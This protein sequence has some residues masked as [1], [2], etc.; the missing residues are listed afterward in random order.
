MK[1]IIT[2]F[3]TVLYF[4]VN[5]QTIFTQPITAT[6]A[7]LGVFGTANLQIDDAG[8][9]GKIT[10]PLIVVE[11]FDSGLLGIENVFGENHIGTFIRKSEESESTSL[12]EFLTG[13]T[14]F[15]FGDQDFDIIY[16]NWDNGND[17]LQRNAF[18]LEE[19]IIWVN[20][21]K[22]N[23]G[24]TTPNVVLGQ[25]MGGIIARYALADM[26][27][28]NKN[29]DTSLYISHDA[30]HQGANIPLGIQY[31]ARHMIDQ[32]VSTPLGDFNIN[33]S[34]VGGPVTIE[35]I[36]TLLNAPGTK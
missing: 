2:L 15:L 21:Q 36:K 10:K 25:S 23:A 32:F 31:F 20:A 8:G 18:V 6:K 34:G 4:T 26:E 27:I 28:N 7:H 1:Y 3:F 24:S 17:Y 12:R 30:P 16:V 22:A 33:I 13:G 35:D 11:G 14:E 5:A 19:V 9:D 29:H